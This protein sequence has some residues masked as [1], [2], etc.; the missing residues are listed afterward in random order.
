LI[1]KH[2]KSFSYEICTDCTVPFV[3]NNETTLK[4]RIK[5]HTDLFRSNGRIRQNFA[6]PSG[7]GS[8]KPVLRIR[9]VYPGSRILIF[10]HPGSRIQKQKRGVKKNLLSY[11]FLIFVATK[12]KIILFLEC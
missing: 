6:D 3:I 8:G 11:H 4:Y 9:D 2:F 5:N 1:V 10:T 7:S 12:L